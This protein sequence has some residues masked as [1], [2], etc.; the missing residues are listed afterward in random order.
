MSSR[1]SLPPPRP[2]EMTPERARHLALTERIAEEQRAAGQRPGQARCGRPLSDGVRRC[3]SW[4]LPGLVGCA[5]HLS[6]EEWQDTVDFP[7]AYFRDVHGGCVHRTVEQQAE[8]RRRDAEPPA[9]H[10]WPYLRTGP[11]PGQDPV[12]LLVAWHADRCAGCG[13]RSPGDLVADHSPVRA[14][15]RPAVWHLQHRRG[16]RTATASAMAALPHPHA[17]TDSRC[18]PHLR[19]GGTP[20]P[21]PGPYPAQ[22]PGRGLRVPGTE[23]RPV[24]VHEALNR[25]YSSRSGEA[26]DGQVSVAAAWPA[27]ACMK[28]R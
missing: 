27:A 12:D 14:G 20:A 8:Q 1:I 7:Q 5:R 17:C 16:Q 6:D 25:A 3:T 2:P 9:C 15:A 22:R 18:A 26:S 4:P 28:E 10:S 24:H 11:L 23:R 21:G 19:A 13:H